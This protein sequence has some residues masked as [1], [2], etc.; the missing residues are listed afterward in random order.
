VAKAALLTCDSLG[1][2]RLTM[3]LLLVMLPWA[4]Y[5]AIFLT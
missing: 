1:F 2:Y 3:R 5:K 4:F